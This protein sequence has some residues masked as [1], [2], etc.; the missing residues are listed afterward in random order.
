MRNYMLIPN[1]A[2]YL[3]QKVDS[4][5]DN[6][7]LMIVKGKNVKTLFT[8]CAFWGISCK[9]ILKLPMSFDEK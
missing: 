8:F 5:Q 2:T 7:T 3:C 4:F 6:S 1:I 9:L